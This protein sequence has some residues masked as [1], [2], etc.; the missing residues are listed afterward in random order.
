M[1]HR[2]D[3]G[4][5]YNIVYHFALFDSTRQ[6]GAQALHLIA[7][8]ILTA[9]SDATDE[10]IVETVEGTRGGAYVENRRNKLS[11]SLLVAAITSVCSSGFLLFG[12]DQGLPRPASMS[13][14]RLIQGHRSHVR[15]RH[16][17]VLA[18]PNGSSKYHHGQHHN[19][20][21]RRW[22]GI[23]GNWRRRPRRQTGPKAYF[24]ARLCCTYHWNY[25]NG[26]VLRTNSNDVRS[27]SH[28]IG[29][30]LHHFR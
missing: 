10:I 1:E 4:L 23:W 15:D 21:V 13:S 5:H 24:D 7:K 14:F 27:Y 17:T 8:A 25:P 2:E 9:M 18:C 19:R 16:L 12:Y 20:L 3:L 30:W 29:N 22:R 6:H 11:G 28:R 26:N